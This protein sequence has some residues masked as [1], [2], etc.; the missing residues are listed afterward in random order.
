MGARG[1]LAAAAAGGG[2]A[3]AGAASLDTAAPALL[4]LKA[5]RRVL[6]SGG[7][8]KQGSSDDN[9]SGLAACDLI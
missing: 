8:V 4:D 3:P 7:S 1:L 2:L 9:V 6:K 5:R